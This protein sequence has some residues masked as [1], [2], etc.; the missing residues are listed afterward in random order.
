[1]DTEDEHEHLRVSENTDF[2]SLKSVL[3]TGSVRLD[4]PTPTQINP[5]AWA[6]CV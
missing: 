3:L 4:P 6:A 1:M 5:A 2:F